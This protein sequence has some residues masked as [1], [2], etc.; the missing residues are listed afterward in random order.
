MQATQAPASPGLFVF[1]LLECAYM[2]DR[3]ARHARLVS[4]LGHS[5]PV[6][7]SSKSAHVRY[8]GDSN[9]ILHRT[10]MT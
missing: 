5:G 4:Q 9:Q 1:A 2:N 3:G 8:A 6:R 7:A 10:A